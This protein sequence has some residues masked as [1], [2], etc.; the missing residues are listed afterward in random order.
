M[1][2]VQTTARKTQQIEPRQF[3]SANTAN[4]R[5]T[6]RT[7]MDDAEVQLLVGGLR[8]FF[9]EL[10]IGEMNV[11]NALESDIE[12]LESLS[13]KT[14]AWLKAEKNIYQWTGPY[15]RASLQRAI[16]AGEVFVVRE[17]KKLIATLTIDRKPNP[18]WGELTGENALYV[19][20]LAIEKSHK[21]TG[22]GRDLMIWAESHS[23]N[24]H[25][26]LLRLDCDSTNERLRNFYRD[27][28]FESRGV[29][30]YERYSMTLELFEKKVQSLRSPIS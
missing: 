24:Q 19:H 14:S 20:R 23:R 21:G 3:L 25:V 4:V 8:K 16:K 11:E 26:P 2:E 9:F 27:L 13:E 15:P 22:L 7:T 30:P 5:I 28:G 10:Y 1:P 29:R 17:N 18:V 6:A 12:C